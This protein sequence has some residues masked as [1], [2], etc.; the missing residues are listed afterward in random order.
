[1]WRNSAAGEYSNRRRDEECVSICSP[2]MSFTLAAVSVCMCIIEN[3]SAGYVA[4]VFRLEVHLD[5]L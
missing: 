2:R 5:S 1:M 4:R 3:G